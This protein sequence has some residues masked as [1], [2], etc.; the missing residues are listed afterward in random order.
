M[1][2]TPHAHRN[3]REPRRLILG[4]VQSIAQGGE[5]EG[6]GGFR[7]GRHG[8]ELLHVDAREGQYDLLAE[9][10][11]QPTVPKFQYSSDSA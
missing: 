10:L 4:V 1:S 3:H 5:D 9:A 6:F 7:L 8:E 2:C 11:G